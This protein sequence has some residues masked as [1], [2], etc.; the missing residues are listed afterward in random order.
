MLMP[1]LSVPYPICTP[2][3]AGRP[4]QACPA[5]F[6][7][8]E[9]AVH[10]TLLLTHAA[11]LTSYCPALTLAQLSCWRDWHANPDLGPELGPLTLALTPMQ[12]KRG[13]SFCSVVGIAVVAILICILQV[14]A[15]PATF[16]LNPSPDP[17]A[18]L[19]RQHRHISAIFLALSAIGV[20][21]AAIHLT[22][23]TPLRSHSQVSSSRPLV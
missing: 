13:V 19:S 22:A 2:L 23:P 7:A 9:L 6:I 18:D 17:V 11:L 12:G 20:A 1:S 14:H 8:V 10:M 4:Y 21:I 15:P 3:A 16:N 5:R